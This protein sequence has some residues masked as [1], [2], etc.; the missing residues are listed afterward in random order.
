MERVGFSETYT[1]HVDERED[2]I[3]ILASTV[4][5]DLCTELHH[6]I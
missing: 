2:G 6:K 4:V 3:L 1:I 5:I